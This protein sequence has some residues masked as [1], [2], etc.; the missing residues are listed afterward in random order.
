MELIVK[1]GGDQQNL[2]QTLNR[3]KDQF[4]NANMSVP[5]GWAPNVSA[6]GKYGN[7][8]QSAPTGGGFS[9]FTKELGEI[10]PAVGGL[11][12][13]LSHLAGPLA[14]VGA[15]IGAVAFVVKGSIDKLKESAAVARE[16]R[17]TGFSASMVKNIRHAGEMTMG[18]DES[19]MAMNKLNAAAGGFLAGDESS[20]KL[21]DELGVNPSGMKSDEML[22]AVK[23][24]MAG[25]KDP[26]KRARL[27]KGLFGKGAFEASE[28]LSKLETEP[29]AFEQES[30]E[31][32]AQTK[33]TISKWW[34]GFMRG[35]DK[36]TTAAVAGLIGTTG[37]ASLD[38]QTI[39]QE[40]ED[41]EGNRKRAD[42][43]VKAEAESRKKAYERLPPEMK[44]GF[45]LNDMDRLKRE[46]GG[47]PAGSVAAGQKQEEINTAEA[48][49]RTN[50][51]TARHERE[52]ERKR[53]E[54]NDTV[55]MTDEQKI[56]YLQKQKTELETL[57]RNQPDADGKR[58]LGRSIE[59][60][61]AE[62][63]G[64]RIKDDQRPKFEADALAQAGLF[65]GSS[66]LLNPNFTIEQQQLEVLQVIAG[67]TG[68]AGIFTP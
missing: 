27:S 11:A 31:K 26:A 22:K 33:R 51:E 2:Q 57:R 47:L 45:L 8:M 41:A 40:G 3:I 19:M 37:G 58:D 64:L 23:A 29:D 6:L 30:I 53:K 44:V 16:S 56:S 42:A 59:D 25:I 7:I 17:I 5:A 66:L 12:S 1:I 55:G 68:R 39:G 9:Q 24:A 62:I 18:S 61:D 67:N 65:A 52:T 43:Q 46:L 20:V 28:M 49:L 48:D 63:K 14:A 35:V 36:V 15:A 32:L 34:H 10:N 60:L 54:H 13:K 21:F 38:S 50:R 4:K